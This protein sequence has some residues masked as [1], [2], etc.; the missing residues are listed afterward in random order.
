MTYK[1][2][3]IKLDLKNRIVHF[4]N[5]LDDCTLLISRDPSITLHNAE[6]KV[7]DLIDKRIKYL[8]Y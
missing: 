7:L 1:G 8:T 5:D 2:Y 4:F 3:K 6:L